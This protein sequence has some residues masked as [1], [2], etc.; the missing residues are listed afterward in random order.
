MKSNRR[1]QTKPNRVSYSADLDSGETVSKQF[2]NPPDYDLEDCGERLTNDEDDTSQLKEEAADNFSSGQSC[3]E[4]LPSV[5]PQPQ[6]PQLQQLP[7]L[8]LPQ[9]QLGPVPLPPP[10]PP[11][12]PPAIPLP[13][14]TLQ[15]LPPQ[16]LPLQPP[17]PIHIPPQLSPP[18]LSTQLTPLTPQHIVPHPLPPQQISPSQISPSQI[19]P[20]QVSPQHIPAQISQ[21]QSPLPSPHHQQHSPPQQQSTV[22]SPTPPLPPPPPPPQQSQLPPQQQ[23]QQ[24]QQQQPLLE[25]EK[26][27]PPQEN[28]ISGLKPEHWQIFPTEY[29]RLANELQQSIKPQSNGQNGL[30]PTGILTI[31]PTSVPLSSIPGLDPT[32]AESKDST[33]ELSIKNDGT[34]I[35]HPDAYCE[36]CDREFCNKYF[37]KTHKANKHGI[38]ENAPSPF[39]MNTF[40]S[41][42][43]PPPPQQQPPQ[44]QIVTPSSYRLDPQSQN[45][46]VIT[47]GSVN[48]D[49]EDYCEL[50][51]KH[52]CNKYYLKKHKQDV[53]GIAPESCNN[54]RR[55]R[56]VDIPTSVAVTS[57]SIIVPQS[58]ASM[59]NMAGVM[60]LNPFV[61]PV[62]IIPAQ[63]LLHQPQPQM[64][65]HNNSVLSQPIATPHM[66]AAPTQQIP[67]PQQ[68]Q[69][70]MQNQQQIQNQQQQQQPQLQ[71]PQQQQL[72]NQ[73]Q[74]SPLQNHQQQHQQQHLQNHQQQLQTQQ[75]PNHQQQQLQTQQQQL[76]NHQ[77]VLQ[78]QIQNHQQQIQNHQQQQQ[79]QQQQ[80]PLP[81]PLPP[82]A[83]QSSQ[84]QPQPPSSSSAP[85]AQPIASDA[86][87]SIGVLN[88]EAYCEICRKEFCNKY[89]LKIHKA[90]MHNIYTDE[91]KPQLQQPQI[92][93]RIATEPDH[94][95]VKQEPGLLR[96]QAKEDAL[97][98]RVSQE[99]GMPLVMKPKDMGMKEAEQM[100]EQM[101][102][103]EAISL[104]KDL[105]NLKDPSVL[106]NLAL[107]KGSGTND[108]P[109]NLLTSTGV[110]VSQSSMISSV[111]GLSQNILSNSNS[112]CYVTYCNICNREFSSKYSYRIHRMNVHGVFHETP[113][114][115]HP[116]DGQ[117][118]SD[119]SARIKSMPG[120]VGSDMRNGNCVTD[121]SG[122]P[123][124]FGNMIAAKLADRVT[125][126]ICSKELCNKYFLKNH[127]LKVHGIDIMSA[128][129]ENK[130]SEGKSV[131]PKLNLFKDNQKEYIRDIIRDQAKEL[132][133]LEMQ[134]VDMNG[135]EFLTSMCNIEK[136]DHHELVKMG[137]DPEAYCEICKKE[138]CSKYFLRTHKLNIHG[139]KSDRI[140]SK[141]IDKMQLPQPNKKLINNLAVSMSM[142]GFQPNE[143]FEKHT[144][145]WKEPVNS[146]RVI[147][148]I[149]NKELCNKYFLRT[150]KLNKHGILP[151]AEEQKITPSPSMR[152]SPVDSG[153]IGNAS[154]GSQ[155]EK[156]SD[157]FSILP[158]S[159]SDSCLTNSD[160]KLLTQHQQ[161]PDEV[162]IK[163]EQLDD[164]PV[165]NRY[166]NH[167]TEVCKLCD[168]R[169]KNEKWLHAHVLKD[170]G[171]SLPSDNK[172]VPLEAQM[173]QFCFKVFPN[174]ISLQMHV[175]NDHKAE[176]SAK[177]DFSPPHHFGGPLHNSLSWGN[178]LRRK[179]SRGGKPKLYSCVHC[180]YKTR[181]LSN[182]YSHEERKHSIIKGT[183]G[184]FTCKTCLKSFL[185][186]HSLIRH[187]TEYHANDIKESRPR[188]RGIRIKKFKCAKCGIKY[189]SKKACQM[190][191]REVHV[192]K[193]K[194]TSDV[195]PSEDNG[196]YSCRQCDFTCSFAKLLQKHMAFNHGPKMSPSS[197]PSEDIE[198]LKEPN[199]SSPRTHNN[200]SNY[201]DEEQLPSTK[202]TPATD[203]D[204]NNNNNNNSNINNSSINNCDM[205]STDENDGYGCRST[206]N[207]SQT[208]FIMQAFHL[209]N[210]LVD[211]NFIPSVVHMPVRQR[212][213]EPVT[214][215]LTLVP[216]EP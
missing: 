152:S 31:V 115:S 123:T 191:I 138:L 119:M 26:E 34:R 62:A 124:L 137:I 21:Q 176:V 82:P 215:T 169:F 51:Q 168:R 182:I 37:L 105:T 205:D 135:K 79:T 150:H 126:D 208:P 194:L 127:K 16:Q 106:K 87:R 54:F 186:E 97:S 74:H 7:P 131:S 68:K 91:M 42:I 64:Q 167:F 56:P 211:T 173:C 147:C 200:I 47:E 18:Q 164:T 121:S 198:D 207:K 174:S 111:V 156:L 23:Q 190:H 101:L 213:T 58:M 103:K 206:D 177:P 73:Q 38:Y 30:E 39:S 141:T 76:Q 146:S 139:I 159:L 196:F 216:A 66:E 144:W 184:R 100:K 14:P 63:P 201:P 99:Q 57:S 89:F 3:P 52:F 78:Q 41:M 72:Q 44:E 107:M 81:L 59:P 185:Y 15:Q 28:H 95:D 98:G 161:N 170:H 75:L 202:A 145:R 11:P 162:K 5:S 157:G 108:I 116:L 212:V 43:P 32:E 65:P 50:C 120:F 142:D 187:I 134:K 143:S 171:V 155:I 214:L 179:Y 114:K 27:L 6:V 25:P 183:V 96:D 113:S 24:Q 125:C 40:P 149:C 132:A 13:L 61:P 49:L 195:E 10:P 153:S 1:K 36:I 109:Q 160:S 104:S 84:S 20:P 204:D 45:Q 166:Y 55:I 35:F 151:T 22:P 60:V 203:N 197:M 178:S 71:N 175:L 4:L 192:K 12:P 83:S 117:L 122:M 165:N 77:Q 29:H 69:Q 188:P 85:P 154:P 140:D 70:Q 102:S 129:K 172:Y 88:A 19:S 48:Q 148:D 112:E 210:N 110:N 9:Q 46:K 53:H 128:E 158:N 17:A 8:Q 136:P 94:P 118:P 80:Q 180:D 133:L 86:L 209:E 199:S 193:S 163:T 67:S 90:N 181:W 130:Q 189:L 33:G 93:S 2:E 92:S